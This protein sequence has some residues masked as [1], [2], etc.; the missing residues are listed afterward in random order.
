MYPYLKLASTLVRARFRSPLALEDTGFLP[1]R[2]G[3]TDIDPFRELNHARQIAYFEMARWDFSSR[4]GFIPL[5]RQRRWGFS[6]GGISIRYRRRLTLLQSFEVT[7][8]IICHDERWIYL[9]Q[10]IIRDGQ[11]YSSALVKAGVVSKTGL[12]PVP[13]LLEAL[14][15]ADWNPEVPAWV[16]AWIAAEGQR[17]WPKSPPG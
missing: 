9:L 13:E 1:C 16:N 2:V 5:M 12:V 14:G 6:V 8:E 7:T 3:L 4:V 17:P 15:R 10:E 11:K